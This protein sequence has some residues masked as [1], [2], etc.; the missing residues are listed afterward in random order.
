[1]GLSEIRQNSSDDDK[2]KT[3]LVLGKPTLY[4]YLYFCIEN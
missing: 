1:M 2:F 4:D 3:S